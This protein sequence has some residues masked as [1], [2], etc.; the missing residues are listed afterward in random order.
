MKVR[1]KEHTWTGFAR[2][3]NTHGLGE[4][5]VGFDGEGGMDSMFISDLEVYLDSKDI[6]KDMSQAFKDDDLIT[7]NYN[8]WFREPKNQEETN[9]GY[10]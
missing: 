8:T 2:D 9:R 5:I 4:V 3:F 6:W 10:F 1:N 7:D